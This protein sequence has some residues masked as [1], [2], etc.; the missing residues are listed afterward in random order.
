MVGFKRSEMRLL[1]PLS[2]VTR[3]RHKTVTQVPLVIRDFLL[4]RE[5]AA[6]KSSIPVAWSHVSEY[7]S[8]IGACGPR[9]F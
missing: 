4:R 2:R 7:P 5:P 8:K 9:S 1:P 3:L 6:S